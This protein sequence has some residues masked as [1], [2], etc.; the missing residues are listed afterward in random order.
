METVLIVVDSHIIILCF[1]TN[2]ID[3]IK[4]DDRLAKYTT[5]GK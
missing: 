5:V 4:M 1:C 2:Y 3:D